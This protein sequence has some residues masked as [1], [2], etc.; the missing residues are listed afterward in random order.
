MDSLKDF[1]SLE[2]LDALLE[3]EF[4]EEE[5][6]EE[7][8]KDEETTEHVEE[9]ES[10]ESAESAE[11]QTSTE[12]DDVDD[13]NKDKDIDESKEDNQPKKK[14]TQQEKQNYAFNQMRIENKNLREA[15]KNYT[16]VLERLARMSGY[17]DV[18]SM[19]TQ[20]NQ[21]LDE[22][23]AKNQGVSPEVYKKLNEQ[24]LAI[25]Q[26][27]HREEQIAFDNKVLNLKGA[28]DDVKNQY[29]FSNDDVKEMLG[30]LE[31]EGYTLET[32]V[33][34]PN[35]KFIITGAFGDK[36]YKASRQKELEMEKQQTLL[37]T[38]KISNTQKRV[39]S[40][41][42]DELE[43]ELRAYAKENNYYYD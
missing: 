32:L 39:T 6:T 12:G 27:K 37:D 35:P 14:Y 43:A 21:K 28:I 40:S 2:E 25:K 17:A 1:N 20:L 11:E 22:Q 42:D 9:S 38:T 19:L 10:A 29:G 24:E 41:E 16:A 13:E 15:Q 31:K 34:S 30:V 18:N 7:T 26:L 5:Q 33:A 36:I 3:S 4:A 23:E 8:S